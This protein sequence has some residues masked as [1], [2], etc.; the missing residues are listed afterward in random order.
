MEVKNISAQLFQKQLPY[1]ERMYSEPE[2]TFLLQSDKHIENAFQK[3][4]DLSDYYKGNTVFEEV[5]KNFIDQSRPS[6]PPSS[7]GA[8]SSHESQPPKEHKSE[9]KPLVKS[10]ESFGKTKKTNLIFALLIL[11]LIFFLILKY[12]K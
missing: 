3:Q 8:P 2:D 6:L 4:L 7:L 1:G 10:K 9:S 12:I 11:F 5:K